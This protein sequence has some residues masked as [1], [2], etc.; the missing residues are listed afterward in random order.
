MFAIST[1]FC[2]FS[3]PMKFLP[4]SLQA[5]AVVPLQRN[6][7]KIVSHSLELIIINFLIIFL[8]LTVGCSNSLSP[9]G[10]LI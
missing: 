2:S 3:I 9:I 10:C 8:G 6:G 5:T 7:S 1:Y 4:S